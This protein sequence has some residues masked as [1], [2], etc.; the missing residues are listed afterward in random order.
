[1]STI[2][3]YYRGKKEKGK[4]SV[5]LIHK[6]IDYVLATPYISFKDYW[7]YKTTKGGKQVNKHKSLEELKGNSIIKEHKSI[8]ESFRERLEANFVTAL[9]NGV[10]ITKVW[11]RQCIK[12]CSDVS[13]SKEDISIELLEAEQKELKKQ[14]I[15]EK[16]LISTAVNDIKIQYLSNNDE[17]KKFKTT[18]NWL[19][20]YQMDRGRLFRIKEFN[21]EFVDDFKNW[22]VIEKKNKISTAVGHLKRIK[23]AITYSFTN[24][25][26]DII[27]VHKTLQFL[28]IANSK[29]VQA[30]KDKIVITL[31]FEE[32]KLID[33]LDLSDNLQLREVQKAILIG[34]ETGLRFSDFNQLTD[35]NLKIT[36]DGVEYWEFKANKTKKWVQIAKTE[37]LLDFFKKYGLPKVS[38]LE[39]DDIQLNE[40]LKKVCRF[41][42][43]DKLVEGELSKVV[44]VDNEKVRR[45]V[46]GFYPKY[47]LITTRTFR[48]SFATNYYGKIPV[49]L[50][51]QV[52]GHTTEKSLKEYIN[53]HDDKNIDLG[54]NAM[55]KFH[56]QR[57]NDN[58]RIVG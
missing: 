17:L 36:K 15:I 49:E 11:F 30:I 54:F 46:R 40:D 9:N 18:Y 52:T 19:S 42:K 3:F 56:N 27:E 20:K 38:Y 25:S 8:L 32:L 29:E 33:E 6:S 14:K 37:R 50:I 12:E 45:S 2:S 35:S 4:L 22:A 23:R 57:E 41:A 44:E 5:R 53:V 47:K 43:L 7:I 58:L 34:C 24:D 1:M 28:K 51:M 31:S 39:N 21:Q 16:N 10:V 13:D 26:E 55:S 48:R